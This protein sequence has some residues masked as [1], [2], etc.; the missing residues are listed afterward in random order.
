MKAEDLIKNNA[1]TDIEVTN[2]PTVVFTEIALT[3]INMVRKKAKKTPWIITKERLPPS[4]DDLYIALD[5]RMNPPGCDVCSFNPA[6]KAWTDSKGCIVF[7]THWMM[8][9][10]V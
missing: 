2:G 6:T 4:D 9:P 1:L 10:E 5:N 8:I 3:A 7:P